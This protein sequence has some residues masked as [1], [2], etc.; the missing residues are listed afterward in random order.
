MIDLK[1][2]SFNKH[3]EKYINFF[4]KERTQLKR[5]L[6]EAKIDHIGSTSVKGLGGKEI[7]DILISVPK[8]NVMTTINKLEKSGYEYRPL[9]GDKQRRFLRKDVV[10]LGKKS[11]VHIQLTYDGSPTWL[12]NVA[13]RDYL[14]KNKDMAKQYASIKKEA[15]DYA[16]GSGK[17]YREYKKSFLDRIE[18]LALKGIKR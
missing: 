10:Y 1:K 4:K 9:S 14:I 7:L 3:S 5:L 2:Y 17:K 6:S 12:A 16:K 18:K 11:R 13:L 15:V 8:R